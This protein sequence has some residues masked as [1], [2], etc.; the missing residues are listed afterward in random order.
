MARAIE[1]DFVFNHSVRTYLFGLAIG[2]NL[3]LRPDRE[4]LYLASILHDV[5]LM[6]EH[7]SEGSFELDSARA[8]RRGPNRSRVTVRARVGPTQAPT[9]WRKRNTSSSLTVVD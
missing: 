1:P 8:A 9:P 4:L 7:E 2:E 3:E 5:G 6:P